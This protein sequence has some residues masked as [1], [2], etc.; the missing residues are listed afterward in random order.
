MDGEERN[1]NN[2]M[3][4]FKTGIQNKFNSI[5]Y[6]TQRTIE[7]ANWRINTDAKNAREELLQ[8]RGE[9]SIDPNSPPH[10]LKVE[11]DGKEYVSTRRIEGAQ[12]Y[13]VEDVDNNSFD[14]KTLFGI[15]RSQ[16]L[17]GSIGVL[18]VPQ[19][20]ECINNSISEKFPE[21]DRYWSFFEYVLASGEG[22]NSKDWKVS[23]GTTTLVKKIGNKLF[24]LDENE[25]DK[26]DHLPLV[27]QLDP[28]DG[29]YELSKSTGYL[30]DEE[31]KAKR[32]W[33]DTRAR[34]Y[35]LVKGS[36]EKQGVRVEQPVLRKANL[37]V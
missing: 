23:F 10:F 19:S 24:I 2:E 12:L 35:N 16:I 14:S 6:D 4:E 29:K 1:Q 13:T 8:I 21:G 26:Y 7:A 11:V 37:Q 27:R 34:F 20:A 9:I 28:K 36:S 3:S 25:S 17:D 33:Y 18:Y 30:S 22:Y 5:K 32:S 15:A 31:L